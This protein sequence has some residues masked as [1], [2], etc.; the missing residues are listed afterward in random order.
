M[1]T[2][3]AARMGRRG[4]RR[5]SRAVDSPGLED[6]DIGHLAALGE[7]LPK[8]VFFEMLGDIFDA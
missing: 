6:L 7:V 5:G 3:R 8:T 4:A 2:G 1:K